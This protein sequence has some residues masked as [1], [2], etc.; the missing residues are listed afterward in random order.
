MPL[1]SPKSDTPE[2]NRGTYDWSARFWPP[3][4]GNPF[5]ALVDPTYTGRVLKERVAA[6]SRMAIPRPHTT[7]DPPEPL[8]EPESQERTTPA[9]PAKKD[10]L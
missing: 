2:S 8:D 3:L 5:L 10:T 7:A 9:A 6:L 1:E 4:E